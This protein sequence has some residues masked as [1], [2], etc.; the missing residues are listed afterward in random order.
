MPLV[1][2]HS[3]ELGLQTIVLHV[4]LTIDHDHAR[5]YTDSHH[6]RRRRVAAA[7]L[8]IETVILVVRR[9]STLVTLQ[10]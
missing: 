2:P 4:V 5:H 7:V 8:E 6:Y 1:R 9:F 3:T 10:R